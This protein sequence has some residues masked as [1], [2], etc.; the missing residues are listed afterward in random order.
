MKKIFP[1]V[2][3]SVL[4]ITLCLVSCKRD[5]NSN[6]M[7][8]N[9]ANDTKIYP[10]R[11]YA[12]NALLSFVLP[13]KEE[14]ITARIQIKKGSESE[15]KD[16][17][18]TDKNNI[19]VK[20][21]STKTVYDVRVEL[22]LANERKYSP[23]VH[24]TTQ[25]YDID[26]DKFFRGFPQLYDKANGLFAMEGS[27]YVV[28]GT[29]FSN[30]TIIPVTLRKVD[31]STVRLVLNAKILNDSMLS[32]DIPK[33]IVDN[34]PYS[35]YKIYSCMVGTVPLIGYTSYKSGN[36]SVMG[37]VTILNRDIM[38]DKVSVTASSCPIFTIGGLFGA[39]K[40]KGVCPPYLYGLSMW[41]QER[42]LIIR[43][44]GTVVKEIIMNND[45]GA[46]CDGNGSAAPDPA[47]LAKTMLAYHEVTSVVIRSKLAS[48]TYTAQVMA[49]AQDGTVF[50][51]N[52]YPFSF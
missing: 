49:S 12:Q 1:L 52:E 46:A 4:F 40:T 7:L 26:Y 31:D 43:S 25:A 42:K 21:L 37:D 20:D 16:I 22:M 28:Y 8:Q 38:I 18:Y 29:G 41:I 30:E 39:H 36:Y 5:R 50:Y 34:T 35:R 14:N 6:D 24:F 11:V 2:L 32:F 47:Q 27:Q 13:Y 33:D 44:G 10:L 23:V 19:P 51:S 15:W 9:Y 17:L 45:G 48:G 3:F